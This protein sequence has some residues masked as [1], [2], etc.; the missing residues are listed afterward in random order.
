MLRGVYSATSAMLQL[1][2]KQSITSNN[3]ANANTP[4]YKSEMMVEKPFPEH[5]VS[6]KDNYKDGVTKKQNIGGLSFGVKIDDTITSFEQG[7]L[8][9]SDSF[10]SFAIVGDGFFT[11]TD[12]EGN[13]AFTRDGAFKI[14]TDG[15][16]M[17]S[18]GHLVQGV[19]LKTGASEPIYIGDAQVSIDANNNI[20]LNDTASYRFNIVE[21]NNYD[22]F[23]LEGDNLYYG[24]DGVTAVNNGNYFIKQK[25]IEGSNVDIITETTN[26]MTTLRAY[27]ANQSVLKAFDSTMDLVA[28]NI[29]K[30]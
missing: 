27:E 29:G 25:Y 4:G 30:I 9:S 12:R 17:T 16:L 26:L 7:T 28:N 24:G 19:N 18:A 20:V 13:T 3:I 10:T 2:A 1:Q 8:I 15:Y 6:N 22:N 21:P 14:T 23:K 11:I 5:M